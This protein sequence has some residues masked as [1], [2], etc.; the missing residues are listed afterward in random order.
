MKK[1]PN[2]FIY[3]EKAIWVNSKRKL[4]TAPTSTPV[5]H[6]PFYRADLGR[7]I[8]LL[9]F[10]L[11]AAEAVGNLDNPASDPGF[12]FVIQERPGELRFGL[13]VSLPSSTSTTKPLE[14][15]DFTWGH[16]PSG[17]NNI[18]VS[19]LTLRKKLPQPSTEFDPG[20]TDPIKSV[21]NG[22][23]LAYALFQKP[24]MVAIHAKEMVNTTSSAVSGNN[25][26]IS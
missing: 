9:R 25:P 4:D 6:Y 11:T 1:Y 10:E 24:V 8:T 18:N 13:D 15:D 19:E 26:N 14:W 7:D 5:R 22:A 21:E 2:L 3:A 12:F 23:H 20:V 16:L 17:I